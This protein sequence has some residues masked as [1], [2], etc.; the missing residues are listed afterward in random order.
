MTR[1]PAASAMSAVASSDESSTT[2]VSCSTPSCSASASSV[3]PR[4]A[5]AVRAG[6]ITDT[7][8][9]RRTYTRA[10]MRAEVSV[11]VPSHDR[12]LRL[13]WLLNALEEQSLPAGE[14]EVV[15]GHDSSGPETDELLRTHPLAT[16][17][18]LRHVTLPPGSAPPGR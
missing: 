8:G 11:V 3:R 17:G 1:T 2:I 13:R 15:V 5:A 4:V 18:T 9:T 10:A 6:K 7:S 12:P 14:W 16:A